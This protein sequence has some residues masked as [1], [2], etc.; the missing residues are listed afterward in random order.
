MH[1]QI[2]NVLK[3]VIQSSLVHTV[4][5]RHLSPVITMIVFGCRWNMRSWRLIILRLIEIQNELHGLMH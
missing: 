1:V 3:S 4:V 5:L 2:M